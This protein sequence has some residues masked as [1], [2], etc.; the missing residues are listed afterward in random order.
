ML[1]SAL[2]FLIETAGGLFTVAF[3]LRFFLQWA[4][5]AQRNQI[6][7]FLNALTN[8][9]VRPARRLIPGLWGLDLATLVLVW[10][11]Q[12]LEIFLKLEIGGYQLGTAAGQAI[13]VMAL[14]ALVSVVRMILYILMGVLIVQAV[15]SWINPYSP[16]A[17]ALNTLSRPFLKPFQR[18]IPPVANVDLSPLF[19]IIVCQL[20]LMLP[21]A[22]AES[23]LLK[24]L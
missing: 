7:D 12:F 24:L 8:W 22:L 9:L 1:S 18:L 17:P 19:V 6:T 15:I 10:L 23:Q 2:I 11:V 21:V 3:L 13:A 4:R 16:L 20:L 5:A 14:L